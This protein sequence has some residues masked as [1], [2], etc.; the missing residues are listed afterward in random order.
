MR[1]FR[2]VL[3]A[4][5]A[6]CTGLVLT[7]AACSTEEEPPGKV[8]PLRTVG[9][10]EGALNLLALPGYVEE[11]ADDP[12]VDWVT[13][14]EES[15]GCQVTVRTAS[16]AQEIYER[17]SGTG[18][19]DG[20]LVPSEAFGRLV[21]AGRLAPVNTGLLASYKTLDARLRG[22]VRR[23]DD[24]YGVPAV[25]GAD[26]LLYE[27]GKAQPDSWGAVFDPRES[28]PYHKQ[29]V[30]RDGPHA[31]ASAALYLKHRDRSLKI[32]DPYE[33][34]VEQME[35]VAELLQKQRPNVLRISGEPGETIEAFSVG[36]AV[37]GMGGAYELDVLA[38][39][40]RPIAVA[41]PKEGVT[42]WYAA[43]AVDSHA[44]NPHCMYRWLDWVSTPEVQ[45]RMAEWRGVAP[46]DERACGLLREGFC[47]AY[48]VGDRAYIDR[49]LFA[50]TPDAECEEDPDCAGWSDWTRTWSSLG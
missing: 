31:I 11:G 21:D 30:W 3:A 47:A 17:M 1:Q 15:S 14:F 10:S 49:L 40:G 50:R 38:R 7:L 24:T 33:L 34:T 8:A 16:S 27:T 4:C 22:L 2:A 36:D 25:W 20:A 43:W 35:A 46:A 29:I 45:K 6:L 28:K 26:L 41:S 48:H 44:R 12:A 18:R 37:V 5:T 9:P 13:P 19:Y 32:R 39:G 42:G 23:K